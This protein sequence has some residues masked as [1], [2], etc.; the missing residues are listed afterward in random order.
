MVQHT[1]RKWSE[2][3]NSRHTTE[4]GHES[5][6]RYG[7]IPEGLA[8]GM[9]GPLAW[10]VVLPGQRAQ[11]EGKA[12]NRGRPPVGAGPSAHEVRATRGASPRHARGESQRPRRAAQYA[13]GRA[14]PRSV[15]HG[16]RGAPVQ[17]PP[18][19]RL[20]RPADGC[21]QGVPGRL[22]VEAERAH[23]AHGDAHRDCCWRCSRGAIGCA[24]SGQWAGRRLR[25]ADCGGVAAGCTGRMSQFCGQA[26]SFGSRVLCERRVP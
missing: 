1:S 16:T 15:R 17:G 26:P 2:V 14:V 25:P 6:A 7:D 22:R 8:G 9:G 24:A 3:A 12:N 23:S 21:T 19:G 11:P 5:G 20:L 10:R 13:G 18:P 4:V